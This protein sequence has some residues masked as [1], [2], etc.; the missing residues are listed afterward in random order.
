MLLKITLPVIPDFYQGTELCDLNLVDT[1]N[2]KPVDFKK[3]NES[4]CY[5]ENK[6]EKNALN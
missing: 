4:L 5:I 1:D 3:R 6:A 2:R